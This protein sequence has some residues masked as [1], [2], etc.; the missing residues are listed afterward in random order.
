[1]YFDTYDA[2]LSAAITQSKGTLTDCKLYVK[3]AYLLTT[4]KS[5]G[6]VG[7]ENVWRIGFTPDNRDDAYIYNG[8]VK[9]V[10]KE[11]A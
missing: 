9:Q 2:A 8:E 10:T 5:T 4:S 3:A 7:S 1:M 11:N 6:M